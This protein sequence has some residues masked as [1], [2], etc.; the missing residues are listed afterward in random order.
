MLATVYYADGLGNGDTLQ[1][2][3]VQV[4]HTVARIAATTE[5]VLNPPT[6]LE[7]YSNV[8]AG[9]RV[10]GV[11]LQA[12]GTA[13]VDLSA[14]AAHIQGSAAAEG[15]RA[16]LVYSLTEIP[17]VNAVQLR[18]EGQP[19]VLHGVEWTEPVS[20]SD[21]EAFGQFSVAPVIEFTSHP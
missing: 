15:F 18:V 9:T 21:V 6:D 1:P 5:Q 13:V 12:D 14:E 4:P 10:L 2:V 11:N 3:Q 7:L 8:P 20:R 19:A 17:G 16:S